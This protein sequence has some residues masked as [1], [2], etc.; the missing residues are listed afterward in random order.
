MIRSTV[1]VRKREKG[2]VGSVAVVRTSKRP[3]TPVASA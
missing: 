2:V 3:S 1:R